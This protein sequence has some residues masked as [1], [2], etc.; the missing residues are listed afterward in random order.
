VKTYDQ[1]KQAFVEAI[2]QSQGTA[3]E[4]V[5]QACEAVLA[6]A[7]E[8]FGPGV[9]VSGWLSE[10]DRGVLFSYKRPAIRQRLGV[11]VPVSDTSQEASEE[12]KQGDTA[13]PVDSDS[14]G[15]SQDE[16]DSDRLV[17]LEDAAM[18]LGDEDFTADGRPHVDAVNHHLEKGVKPFTA[19]ERDEVWARRVHE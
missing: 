11:F 3:T 17:I 9:Y 12:A 19:A 8:Q 2:G 6:K 1:I 18:S 7:T 16:S 13:Q 5:S 4:K 15:S 14:P 10:D